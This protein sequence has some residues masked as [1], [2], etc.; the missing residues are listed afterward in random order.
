MDGFA[1]LTLKSGECYEGNFK[2]GYPDGYG[3][4]TTATYKYQ[5][6]F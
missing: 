2:N 3:S 5:G 4:Y 6:E 1:I